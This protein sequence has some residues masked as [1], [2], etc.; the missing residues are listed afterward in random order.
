MTDATHP[1]TQPLPTLDQPG[2]S[3][4][5]ETSELGKAYLLERGLSLETAY[6]NGVEIDVAPSRI[7]IKERLAKGCPPIWEYAKEIVWFPFYDASGAIRSWAARPLPTHD[8]LKF[9]T[10]KGGT[11]PPYIPRSVFDKGRKG[12]L[13]ITEGPVK[14]LVLLQAGF[15]AIGLNGVWGTQDKAYDGSSML[16]QELLA[17]SI[18]SRK[19]Y[20]A[21]D[22]DTA[23]DPHIRHAEIRL[24]FLLRATG[25]QV[26][27]LSSWQPRQGKGIDDFLVNRTEESPS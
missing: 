8:K 3:T 20:L 4:E 7:T 26:Y 9:V 27:Q 5:S 15:N 22:V 12:A 16:R 10:P 2:A 6:A 25:A 21:L 24:F 17:L 1:E 11:G 19:V 18:H 23:S 13:F 14:T